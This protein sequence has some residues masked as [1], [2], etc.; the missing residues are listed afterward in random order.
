MIDAA[1]Q[2]ILDLIEGFRRSKVMFTAVSLGVFERLA[3]GPEEAFALSLRIGAS[4]DTTARL[5]DACVS[6]GL[7][8]KRGTMYANADVA[9]VY[10]LRGSPRTMVGYILYSDRVLY[11]MWGHL[12]DA[13]R[14]GTHR[15]KQTFG[16][17]GALFSHFFKTEEDKRTFLLGMHGMGQLS[18]PAVASAFDLAGYRRVVD[19]GGATG[20]LATAIAERYPEIAAA[21]FDLPEVIEYAREFTAGSR[22]ELIEGDFFTDALPEADLYT[23]GRILHD[24][25]ED[26]IERLLARVY[27]ALPAGGAL[28]VAEKLLHEDLAGPASAH[29]QSLNMLICTEGRE[30]SFAQYA[31]LLSQAGFGE[32]RGQYTNTPL[33]AVLAIKK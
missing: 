9:T 10:L 11:P 21:V 30:R 6:L 31:E 4:E 7:L 12:D 23:L 19:L 22:V 17:D 20:H 13:L 2:P 27:A 15:W 26:K 8:E 5:L 33:D 18:S 28:L 24:W 14:E 29:M 16:L 25:S 3:E 1:P 32:V